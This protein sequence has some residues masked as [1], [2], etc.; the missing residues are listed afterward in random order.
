MAVAA[1]H[2]MNVVRTVGVGKCGVH[3]GDIQSAVG[4]R[5][6]TL[7]AGESGVVRMGLMARQTT[8]TLV[9]AARRAVVAGRRL[10]KGVGRVT[11][12]AEPLAR[13]VGNQDWLTLMSDLGRRQILRGKMALFM[14]VIKCRFDQSGQTIVGNGLRRAVVG[15]SRG[16]PL[17]VDFVAGE[18]GNDRALR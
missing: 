17:A 9:N 11:L 12:G 16:H 10:M 8:Q 5:R 3:G 7:A 1:R 2:K 14:T 13:I 15:S 6:M 4:E 18:A